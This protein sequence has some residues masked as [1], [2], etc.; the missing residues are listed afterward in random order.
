M[1][2]EGKGL[3]R[4]GVAHQ[5]DLRRGRRTAQVAMS[6]KNSSIKRADVIADLVLVITQVR[7]RD[8]TQMEIWEVTLQTEEATQG[9][10]IERGEIA[11]TD[12]VIRKIPAKKGMKDAVVTCNAK[13][14][15][16][17]LAHEALPQEAATIGAVARH[18]T[19]AQ[20]MK[21]VVTSVTHP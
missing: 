12:R 1:G 2:G 9:D 8:Q 4:D 16:L 21:C 19:V 14:A 3:A 11:P 6:A 15:E 18:A 5:G 13:I 7:P 17:V 20:T 10:I